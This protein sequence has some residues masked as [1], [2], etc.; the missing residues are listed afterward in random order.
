VFDL[1]ITV[2]TATCETTQK[3]ALVLRTLG[4]AAI[5]L[6]GKMSQPKRLAALNNFKSGN[7][8]I[9]IGALTAFIICPA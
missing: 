8:N 2:F 1:F 3:V 5:P 4:F 9:L 7:R 6:H